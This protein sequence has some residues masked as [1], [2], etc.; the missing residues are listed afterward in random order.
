M[1]RIRTDLG[2]TVD[3]VA[4]RLGLVPSRRI[5]VV[6]Q[7]AVVLPSLADREKTGRP[8]QDDPIHPALSQLVGEASEI[9]NRWATGGEDIRDYEAL[10]RIDETLSGASWT[11]V[12]WSSTPSPETTGIETDLP[13]VQGDCSRLQ[14]RLA[15]ETEWRSLAERLLADA[16]KG[17][18]EAS[19]RNR[20]I[21]Q[22][23]DR[24]TREM[25]VLAA[26]LTQVEDRWMDAKVRLEATETLLLEEQAR[27]QA[28][29]QRYRAILESSAWC[30]T[31]PLRRVADW[32][33]RS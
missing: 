24:Q 18:R 2:G 27:A 9:L 11:Y 23:H 30:L 17:L 1:D 25:A 15:E 10:D 6:D 16:Q 22:E 20:E 28:D 3:F 33:R 8:R 19:I 7:R 32:I 31:A 12:G 21:A 13:A 29:E 5:D 14:R 26:L 4:D